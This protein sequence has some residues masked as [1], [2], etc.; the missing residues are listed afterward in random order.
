[1]PKNTPRKR[2]VSKKGSESTRKKIKQEILQLLEPVAIPLSGSLNKKKIEK[3]I[4]K[5]A[6][7]LAKGIKPP[8]QKPTRPNK[9]TSNP[10]SVT[11]KKS[12][13][14]GK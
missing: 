8:R 11:T 12:T 14:K 3:R 2:E 10:K 1:M 7:V 6:K 5:A 13:T 4:E 9:V